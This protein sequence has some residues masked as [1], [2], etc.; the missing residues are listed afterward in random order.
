MNEA[1]VRAY[2]QRAGLRVD[3]IAG[4]ITFASLDRVFP[5]A[6]RPIASGLTRII[7][8]WTAGS[9]VVSALDREHYHFIIDGAGQVVPGRR[10]P[11][12]NIS[13]SDGDYAA[14]TRGANTGAIGVAV[15]GM[16]NAMERPFS[17]GSHPL[18]EA[19]IDALVGLCASLCARYGIAVSPQTVL[20]HAEVQPTLGIAQR[21]KWDITWLPGMNQPG[22]PI[23]VG[24]IL[25]GRILHH[26]KGA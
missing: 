21:G 8:H 17:P 26:M 18:R 7:M 6:A 13:A 23:A 25:R 12:A 5:P 24:N 22:D 20:T 9:H 1:F 11:E 3:G 16:L 2:Q 19:Q 10:A 15:A 4:P 14:H